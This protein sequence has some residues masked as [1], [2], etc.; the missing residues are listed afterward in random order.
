MVLVSLQTL[1]KFATVRK[2]RQELI[3]H[4]RKHCKHTLFVQAPNS[5][6]MADDKAEKPTSQPFKLSHTIR[7][8]PSSSTTLWHR[9]LTIERSQ[10]MNGV[11]Q[12]ID[13]MQKQ[14]NDVLKELIEKQKKENK[15][16]Q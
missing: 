1:Q 12:G 6:G 9:D 10:G 16:D 14:V 8:P 3:Q 13:I 11:I 7:G 4:R 2:D 15:C 5:I